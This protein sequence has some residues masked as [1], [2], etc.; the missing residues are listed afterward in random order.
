MLFLGGSYISLIPT[1]LFKSNRM[2]QNQFIKTNDIE[3][4]QRKEVSAEIGNRCNYHYCAE[5]TTEQ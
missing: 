5:M 1:F 4:L 3:E 2:Q